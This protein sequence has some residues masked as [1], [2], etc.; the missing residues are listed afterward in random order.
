MAVQAEGLRALSQEDLAIFS[1]LGYQGVGSDEAF[2]SDYYI[3]PNGRIHSKEA[4][5]PYR[6]DT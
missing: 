6:D 5:S 4:A 1:A 3:V 2:V